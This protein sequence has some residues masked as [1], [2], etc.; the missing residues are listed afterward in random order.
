MALPA[1]MIAYPV[2]IAAKAG[3]FAEAP[4]YERYIVQ[5]IKQVLLTSQGER[6]NRIEFGASVR[7]LLFSPLSQGVASFTETMVFHAL[8]RWLGDLIKV[9]SLAVVAKEE[10]LEISVNYVILARG[11]K[12]YLT[13]EVTP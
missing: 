8:T 12:R 13:M 11:E 6:I 10:T 7:K 9:D 4:D 5:L 1:K 2:A 3:R